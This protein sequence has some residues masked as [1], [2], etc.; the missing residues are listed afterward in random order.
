MRIRCA[1]VIV[2]HEGNDVS[3]VRHS[4]QDP[5]VYRPGYHHSIVSSE[6]MHVYFS[7]IQEIH[8]Y[9]VSYQYTYSEMIISYL[10]VPAMCA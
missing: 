5:E 4:R 10:R 1:I 8:A 9:S 2:T 3:L 6:I 7:D